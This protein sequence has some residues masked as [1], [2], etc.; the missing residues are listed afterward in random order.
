MKKDDNC[1]FC[2]IIEG[3][4][5]AAKVYEDD[6][7]TAFLDIM[8]VNKGHTLVVPK[9][10]SKNILEDDDK[11]IAACMNVIKK[12]GAAV[13]KAMKAD[14]FNIGVNTERA[15]GQA[16]FHTHFHVIPRF[17]NDGLHH[18]P[19]GKYDGEE[20]TKVKQLIIKSI[21]NSQK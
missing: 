4:I 20:I 10:H 17:Q 14:G 3:K 21:D 11:D 6:K 15:A 2:K 8:P 19:G 12:V 9:S 18:W 1:I 5:P 16:I 7:V 13:I